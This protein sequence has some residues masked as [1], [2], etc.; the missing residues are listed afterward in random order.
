M[1][2][3]PWALFAAIL[4]HAGFSASTECVNDHR[5]NKNAGILITDFTIAGTQTISTTELADITRDMIGSCFDENSEEM[6]ERVRAS[7][8]DG[9]YFAVEVKSLRFKPRDPLGVPKPVTLEG[10]VSEGARYKLAE[11][12]F[13][14]NHAFSSETLRQQFPL[15]RGDLFRRGK[16]A[17]GL[18]SLRKL[19]GTHGFLDWTAVPET[20]FGSSATVNLNISS[21]EGHQ[22]HMGKLETVG[23]KELAAKLRANW[24]LAEGE[25]YDRTYIDQFLEINRDSLPAGFSRANV[26][27]IQ[28]CPDA[29]VEV[30]LILDPAEETSH[31]EPK[32]V[33]CEEHHDVRK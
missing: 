18:Q 10:E 19:Y 30:R 12:T 13:V 15:K 20:T 3:T 26:Q 21:R 24:N 23:D 4:A 1:R 9:G 11:I 32:N 22:Y 28:N 5:S 33:P 25:V 16:V 31:A 29:L 7:F 2:L 14:E 27:T 6:E 17:S 8:Q